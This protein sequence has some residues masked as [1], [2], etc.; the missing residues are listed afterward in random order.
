MVQKQWQKFNQITYLDL[1][2]GIPMCL[3]TKPPVVRLPTEDG[4][5]V[6]RHA[7]EFCNVLV[8]QG[9]T[10]S[11]KFIIAF[12]DFKYIL[13]GFTLVRFL[14]LLAKNAT[15]I[16]ELQLQDAPE[17]K[18]LQLLFKTNKIKK[19]TINR[20][21]HFWPYVRLPEMSELIEFTIWF[22]NSIVDLENLSNVVKI[23]SKLQSLCVR[24]ITVEQTLTLT[25]E[26]IIL[27][28]RQEKD[29]IVEQCSEDED[30]FKYKKLL[31]IKRSRNEQSGV[32][33]LC[34]R[35]I[36]ISKGHFFCSIRRLVRKQLKSY[37]VI[38]LED[39]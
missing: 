37:D 20:C 1:E 24:G 8:F 30:D 32:Q 5:K 13:D 2:L 16:E 33:V 23:M 34:L 29:V 35:F 22:P 18:S 25:C 38:K 7:A 6:V 4:E 39:Y 15:E 17:I 26:V 21:N 19:L 10:C 14:Q 36:N 28:A 11:N 9:L 27:A 31:K 12:K 3:S